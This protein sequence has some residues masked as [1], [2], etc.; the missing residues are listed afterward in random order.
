M[1]RGQTKQKS[2]KNE[3]KFSIGQS[4]P[5]SVAPISLI[6]PACTASSGPPPMGRS[7][8]G[9]MGSYSIVPRQLGPQLMESHPL[10]PYSIGLQGVP[11]RWPLP[12]MAAYSCITAFFNSGPRSDRNRLGMHPLRSAQQ[13]NIRLASVIVSLMLASEKPCITQTPHISHDVPA[14]ILIRRIT[15]PF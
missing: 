1:T 6:P 9:P 10:G 5:L 12:T 13:A 11:N 3:E 2:K 15:R 8:I 4:K 7:S 14:S